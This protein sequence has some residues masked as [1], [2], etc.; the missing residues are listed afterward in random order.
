[1]PT[2]QTLIN[3]ALRGIDT[4]ATTADFLAWA[5][6]ANQLYIGP[7]SRLFTESATKTTIYN[8]RRYDLPIITR[9]VTNV[10]LE[11][12]TLLDLDYRTPQQ[13]QKLRERST[14][15]GEPKFYTQLPF[16]TKQIEIYPAPDA[17]NS[18]RTIVVS[19]VA[20][21]TSL[22]ATTQTPDIP[23]VYHDLYTLYMRHRAYDFNDQDEK[24]AMELAKFQS[25]LDE[26][27]WDVFLEG[28]DEFPTMQVTD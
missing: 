11:G 28:E 25:R 26:Y 2:V 13:M 17:R 1:M 8:V 5:E 16:S 20:F 19:L 12:D 18:N 9:D 21:P 27:E 10:A 15:V 24:A 4:K 14:A 3:N 23:S 6:E 7:K 22:T